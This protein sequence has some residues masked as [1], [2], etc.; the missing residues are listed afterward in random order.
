MIYTR[1]HPDPNPP[2]VVDNPENILW[3]NPKAGNSPTIR[4]IHRASSA[5]EHLTVSQD[6]RSDL[7]HTKNLFRTKSQSRVYQADFEPI[8]LQQSS[9]REAFP[10]TSPDFQLFHH[11]NPFRLK[12]TQNQFSGPST[13]ATPIHTTTV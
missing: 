8:Y 6:P 2:T 12:S 7:H 11:F 5:S 3:K 13:L 1:S 4:T 9:S 10:S